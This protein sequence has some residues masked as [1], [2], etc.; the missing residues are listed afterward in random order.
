MVR[1]TGI[2]PATLSLGVRSGKTPRQKFNS[3]GLQ[4]AANSTL[5]T[6]LHALPTHYLFTLP[7]PSA[8]LTGGHPEFRTFMASLLN[9]S[10]PAPPIA[11]GK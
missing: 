8:H 3:F 5:S 1:P 4:D 7:D 11:S 2:E 9:A 10:L 6:P